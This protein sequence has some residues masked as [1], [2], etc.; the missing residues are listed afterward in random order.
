MS[1]SQSKRFEDK[2]VII[3]GAGRGIGQAT[4]F[5]FAEEGAEVMLVGRTVSTLEDTAGQIA[6]AGG[7]AWVHQADVTQSDQVQ[8]IADAAIGRSGQIDILVNNAGIEDEAAFLD[9]DEKNW[10][11]VIT[12]N[13]KAYFL[14]SQRVA[15]EM[16]KTGG[17]VIL[18]NAS[19]CALGTDGPY[20]S[21]HTSKAALLGL[22]RAM[23]F[24][25]AQ[26]N[27]RVNCVSPGYTATDMIKEAVGEKM[28]E[29]LLHSFDRVPMGRM[30]KPS[31]VAA[32]FA[33]LASDDAS[34]ITGA[35]LVVDCGLTTNLY[36]SES[37]PVL[38]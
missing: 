4:A 38:E 29:Y 23:A 2:T 16:V 17:G 18:L 30:V 5:R 22:N 31:E 10:D 7:N 35:N 6:Q 37:M 33:F 9:I 19:I 3:T 15:R 1:S 25:L 14:L 26:H 20:A 8:G 21:Y 24:E 34:A 12:T 36:I 11:S 28:L 13:Q 27:I 32:T